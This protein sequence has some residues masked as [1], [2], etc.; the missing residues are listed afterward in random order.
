MYP[1]SDADYPRCNCHA[2]PDAYANSDANLDTNADCYR[3]RM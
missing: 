1:N 3:P 2:D